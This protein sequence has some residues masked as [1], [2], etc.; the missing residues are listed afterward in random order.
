VY[1]AYVGALT[2]HDTLAAYGLLDDDGSA[3]KIAVPYDFCSDAYAWG[4]GLTCNRY[5][6]GI[7]SSEIV[8]NAGQMYEFYYPFNNFRRDRVL[9]YG[10]WVNG[11][12][13]RLYSRTYQPMLNS[14]RYFYY[15]RRSSARLFPGVNDWGTAAMQGMNFFARVLQTPEPGTYCKS[16]TTYVPE[17]QASDCTDSVQLGLDQGRYYNTTWDSEYIFNPQNLGTFWDKA[18]AIQ[19]MTDSEAFFFRDFSSYT[20]RGAFSIGYYRV[21]QPEMLK[22]FG[23]LMSGNSSSLAPVVVQGTNGPEV[24]YRPFL[25]TDIFGNPVDN[26]PRLAAGDP[27]QPATSYQLKYLAAVY[28]MFNLTSTL[29]QTMDFASRARIRLAG[30]ASDPDVDTGVVNPANIKTF[31]DPMSGV[32]YRSVAV[33]GPDASIGYKLLDDAQTFANG[34]WATA[35][36]ALEAAQAGTDQDAIRAAQ[37][38]FMTKDAQ[39]NDKVQII[40]FMVMLGDY[41][42]FPS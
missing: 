26:D 31:T 13:N 15:Y 14:F 12:M 29:D 19:A 8:N 25:T 20:N 6:M 18:I 35:K 23:A 2:D 9:S 32:V 4:G 16:G 36:A 37:I 21:F 28:G 38:D 40:D 30:S 7:T 5:D 3:P 42:E 33:D 27:I 39:L 1:K 41:M 24:V 34:E 10:G 17:A 11:Y 22:M